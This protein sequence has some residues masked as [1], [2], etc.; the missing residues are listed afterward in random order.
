[1]KDSTL[2]S[3]HPVT[4]KAVTDLYGPQA[5]VTGVRAWY[6]PVHGWKDFPAT[7]CMAMLPEQQVISLVE[8]GAVTV[9]LYVDVDREDTRNADFNISELY[10]PPTLCNTTTPSSATSSPKSEISESSSPTS[11][12]TPTP[13]SQ[14]TSAPSPINAKNLPASPAAPKKN[15][16]TTKPANGNASE[17]RK[18]LKNAN[19][20]ATRGGPT[21]N[22]EN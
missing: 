16:A 5:Q 9:Q 19:A 3:A 18:K 12:N 2:F 8:M 6:H 17:S 10:T 14:N 20:G 1:M 22:A 11:R 7:S 15:A 4:W 21:E 13:A